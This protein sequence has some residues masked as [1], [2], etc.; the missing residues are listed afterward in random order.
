MTIKELLKNEKGNYYS[1]E[2]F[3]KNGNL[4]IPTTADLNENVK[5]YSLMNEEE[6]ERTILLNSG[7]RADFAEWYDDEK[8]IILVIAVDRK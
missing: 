5:E 1:W 7:E 3:V 4:Y 6:Y 2:S 8:A